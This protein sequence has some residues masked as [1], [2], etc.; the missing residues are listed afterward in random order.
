MLTFNSEEMKI[1][2][3]HRL[4]PALFPPDRSGFNPESLRNIFCQIKN[5]LHRSPLEK[6]Q[7]RTTTQAMLICKNNG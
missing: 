5:S 6:H 7:Y 4:C 2:Y 1:H 3:K